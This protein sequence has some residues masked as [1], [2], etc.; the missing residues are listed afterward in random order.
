M[1][2]KLRQDILFEAY[3]SAGDKMRA[4]A[5]YNRS[6]PQA[7][8]HIS[9]EEFA[10]REAINL[11]AF[12]MGESA[13]SK[14][15]DSIY[16]AHQPK[17]DGERKDAGVF[18]AVITAVNMEANTKRMVVDFQV[19]RGGQPTGELEYIRTHPTY[20]E[21][22]AAQANQATIL[23]GHRVLIYKDAER[24][25]GGGGYEKSAKV[26][27]CLEDLGAY[28]GELPP[29]VYQGQSPHPIYK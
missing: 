29:G 17:V 24:F 21:E 5:E 2:Q 26:L 11:A 3:R 9:R 16:R 15:V 13:A 23:I 8:S 28:R 12:L 4:Q 20:T 22:G 14:A 27:V 18:Q 10:R 6:N 19:L 25:A 7:L 1:D